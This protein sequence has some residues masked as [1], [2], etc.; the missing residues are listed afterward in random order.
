M[1]ADAHVAD[2]IFRPAGVQTGGGV[3]QLGGV[4]R[5]LDAGGSCGLVDAQYRRIVP[6]CFYGYLLQ[7]GLNFRVLGSLTGRRL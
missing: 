3:E 7:F 5:W 2:V 1:G 4:A 6:I